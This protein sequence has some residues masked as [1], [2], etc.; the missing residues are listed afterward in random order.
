[1][2]L[3]NGFRTIGLWSAVLLAGCSGTAG[4]DPEFRAMR[5][6]VDMPRDASDVLTDVMRDDTQANEVLDNVANVFEV[7]RDRVGVGSLEMDG[8]QE[9][10]GEYTF[11]INLEPGYRYCRSRV[12]EYHYA[13][14][15]AA[16]MDATPDHINV[17]AYL[18]QGRLGQPSFFRVELELLTVRADL[19]GTA[20]ADAV[21]GDPRQ[22]F[23]E[24]HWGGCC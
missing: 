2:S 7:D 24:R 20:D 5:V 6:A 17:L 23:Y 10:D 4:A 8:Y 12:Y 3:S 16:A 15:G 18:A 14:F 19:A 21:C 9:S 11:Q 13:G 22:P 1:M